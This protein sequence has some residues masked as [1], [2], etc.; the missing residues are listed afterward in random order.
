[1]SGKI[2]IVTGAGSGIGKSIARALHGE[3]YKVALFGRRKP[4]L[5]ELAQTL[6]ASGNTAIALPVDIGDRVGVE[7]AFAA[8]TARWG[9]LDLLVNNAGIAGPSASLEEVTGEQWS[10][11]VATNLSG[12]FYCTQFAFAQMKRQTPQGGRIINN[13]SVSATTP[14]PRSAPYVATKHAITGLT[15][16]TS[17]DGRAYNIAA[18][19]IDIGNAS[20]DMT[21]TISSGVLQADGRIAAEPTMN[22]E[23]VARAV[24][25]MAGLPLQANVLNMTVMATAMP[26]VGRG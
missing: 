26:F 3:G 17:L 2:A 23:D 18:G 11:V 7:A 20:T 13:G 15:K 12:A 16:A 22:V 1:M 6:D 25:Y 19:Q 24:L 4:V 5:D 8:V 9:R 10:E 14:R 21:Q